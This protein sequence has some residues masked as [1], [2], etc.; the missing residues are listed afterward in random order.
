[1]GACAGRFLPPHSLLLYEE[2]TKQQNETIKKQK[3]GLGRLFGTT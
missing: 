2:H 1:M 3:P